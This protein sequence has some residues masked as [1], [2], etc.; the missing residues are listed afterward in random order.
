M[1]QETSKK[2][3]TIGLAL[4]GGGARAMAFHLGC[5]RALES[6]K[7]LDRIT[8][9][10]TIS[11]G[12]VIGAYFAYHPQKSFVEFEADIKQIL[13]KGF[14]RDC[15]F[16]LLNPINLFK[17][18][19][20]S[21]VA[22]LSE[23]I[24]LLASQEPIFSRFFTRTDL[25]EK[26]LEQKLYKGLRLST[27]R[28]RGFPIVIGACDLRHGTAFRFANQHSGS[29][30][31]GTLVDNDLPVALAVVASAAYP[32]FLPVL[33]RTWNFLKDA[34]ETQQ[35]VC[36][37]DGGVYDNLGIQVLEPG[38]DSTKSVHNYPCDYIIACNAGHGQDQGDQIPLGFY[39]RVSRS[40][41]IIHRRV[42][43]AAMNRLHQLRSNNS[44]KG[45]VMPY[46]GQQD[47]RINFDDPN[48]VPRKD[49]I[50]YPTDFYAM[51]EAW[52]EKLALRGEQQTKYL[53][54]EYT[55]ELLKNP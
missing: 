3:T 51:S 37:T 36:L 12:S 40:F 47:E 9:L 8:V 17:C 54:K 52:I 1:M 24:A 39:R 13:R 20:S 14:V 22:H 19:V 25:L 26:V 50:S 11:G 2:K 21:S 7:L 53:L 42:Q 15:I 4:S 49:V 30:R 46:L 32:L 16:Q 10:S 34:T 5:L 43:D 55:P 33:D 18:A 41:G 44:L 23:G 28:H 6:V 48:Y 27:S 35:R 31:R 45:F 38:R 29:W